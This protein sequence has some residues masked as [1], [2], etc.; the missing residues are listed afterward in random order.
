MLD[1]HGL[2]SPGAQFEEIFVVTPEDAVS[3]YSPRLSSLL[4]TAGLTNRVLHMLRT[5]CDADLPEGFVTV[6]RTFAMNHLETVMV[7]TKLRVLLTLDAL[8][9]NKLNIEILVNDAMGPVAHGRT[10]RAVVSAPD[11]LEETEARR[12]S[13]ADLE[14]LR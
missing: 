12:R 1:L 7:G 10:E 13:L 9:G 2:Y 5:F 4:S 6:A 11:L 14:A 8:E 3:N